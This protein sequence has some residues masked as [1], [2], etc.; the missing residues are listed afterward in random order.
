MAS[1]DPLQGSELIDCA[2]ANSN[3][4]LSIASERCGYGSNVAKFEEQLRNACQAIGVEI[5]GFSDLNKDRG[6]E[7][8]EKPAVIVAPGTDGQL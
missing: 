2:K 1:S 4:D 7:D 5:Q 8:M 6:V 3:Q